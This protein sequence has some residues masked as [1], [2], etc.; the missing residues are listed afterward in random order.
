MQAE[1]PKTAGSSML[2]SSRREVL[3]DG[4]VAAGAVLL[5]SATAASA[6]DANGSEF[7][8]LT[9]EQEQL[10]NNAGI[11]PAGLAFLFNVDENGKVVTYLPSNTDPA[12]IIDITNEKYSGDRPLHSNLDVINR[13]TVDWLLGYDRE[14]QARVCYWSTPCCDY[15]C[16]KLEA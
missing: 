11:P 7:H 14:I 6:E 5:G 8:I 13:G 3:K 2:E 10:L 12:K 4:I 15:C 9:Q 16:G 1:H